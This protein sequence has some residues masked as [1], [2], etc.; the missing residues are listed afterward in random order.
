M[1]INIVLE[2]KS[3][4][5]LGD[6]INHS[7]SELHQTCREWYFVNKL[8]LIYCEKKMFSY[9]EKTFEI[10][11]WSLKAE[12]SCRFFRSRTIRIQIRKKYWDLETCRKSLKDRFEQWKVPNILLEQNTQLSNLLWK[13]STIPIHWIN[14]NKWLGCNVCLK[15]TGTKRSSYT[16]LYFVSVFLKQTLE[17][18]RNK[19]ENA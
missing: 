12:N 18:Y 11:G 9:Q 2:N 14:Y 6:T 1:S 7:N 13:V 15:K 10:R 8:V 3:F 19:F 4:N 17:T 5:R 16:L